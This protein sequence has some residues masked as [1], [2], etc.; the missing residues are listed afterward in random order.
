MLINKTQKGFT[1][2]MND[3]LIAKNISFKAKGIYG[4]LLSK[5]DGWDFDALRI[6]NESNEGR[7]SVMT[8]L[9]ELEKAG[10]LVRTISKKI[11]GKFQGYDYEIFDRLSATVVPK[12]VVPKRVDTKQ[13]DNSKKEERKKELEIKMCVIE[14]KENI[15]INTHTKVINSNLEDSLKDEV[16]N[17]PMLDQ[18]I[19]RFLDIYQSLRL[20][21]DIE[22]I[23]IDEVVDNLR[24]KKEL[25]GRANVY[26]NDYLFKRLEIRYRDQINDK[27]KFKNKNTQQNSVFNTYDEL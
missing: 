14:E 12:T 24:V 6:S 26:L 1:I 7:K 21:P 15:K 16:I 11:N 4:Y 19:D 22:K 3:I 18:R 13:D 20:I 17:Q 25:A 10:L 8:G 5:P 2:V 9:Q 27:N 23:V